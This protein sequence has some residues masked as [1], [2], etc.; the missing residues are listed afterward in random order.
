MAEASRHQGEAGREVG[1]SVERMKNISEQTSLAM[2]ESAS[3]V[4]EL[5]DQARNLGL[6]VED[7]RL[8]SDGAD[9]AGGH[10]A[11]PELSLV[12]AA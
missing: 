10:G 4:A 5:A 8:D 2:D 1:G 11:E 12:R 7:I 9:G 3:A 6:I